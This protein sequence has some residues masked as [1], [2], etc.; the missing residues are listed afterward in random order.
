MTFDDLVVIYDGPREGDEALGVCVETLDGEW[1]VRLTARA[2]RVLAAE[3]LDAADELGD[4]D[5]AAHA[6]RTA[7][8]PLSVAD[9]VDDEEADGV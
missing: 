6:R 3:Q 2:A 9:R 1:G 5:R 8:E 4:G 7:A